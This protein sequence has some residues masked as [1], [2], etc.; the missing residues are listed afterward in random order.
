MQ[1]QA[2]M[3]VNYTQV[4]RDKEIT[5]EIHR[6]IWRA[7]W[8]D[9]FG[10]IT[11]I[12]SR[13]IAFSS[14]HVLIPLVTALAIQTVIEE[15]LTALNRYLWL[16]MLFSA[17]Y[18]V[19][20]TIGQYMISRSAV[21]ALI[22]IQQ[23]V[24]SNFITKD[25]EFFNNNYIGA[26]GAQAIRLR[27]ASS[28]YG[29]ITIYLIPRHL[30]IIIASIVVIG[31]QSL[32]LAL[33]TLVSMII[34]LAFTML[35]SSWRLKFRRLVS[36]AGSVV[37]GQIGDVLT[38]AEAVKS[39]AAEGYEERRLKKPLEKW[40]KAQHK[41]WIAA[42]P[43][44]NGRLLLASIT[45]AVLL[46]A[47]AR[48]Y[49][50]GELSISIVLL[51]QLY[52]IKLVAATMD[53]A[54]TLKR[55]EE[56]MGAAYEPV[57]T[58][59]L[60]PTVNNPQKP[61]KIK[62]SGRYQLN[63]KCVTYHY[64]EAATTEN[65][66]SNLSLTVKK[67]QKI[68]LVGYSGS[69]KTTLTKLILRY[70]D[71]TEGMISLAGQDIRTVKQEDLR[72]L[73]AYVPQEPILFHRSISENIAYG[74]PSADKKSLHKAAK[75]AYVDEFVSKLPLGYETYVGERGVK[76]SGGQRQR[77]AI[78]RALLKD[79]PILILDEATSSLDSKSEK[80]IQEALWKLMKN[81]TAIVIAHRLST[82]QRMDKIVVMDKGRI[83][84]TGTHEEL[85][86]I[87]GIYADLWTHQSGGYLGSASNSW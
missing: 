75:Q 85:K 27:D 72:K 18:A 64:R 54:D 12:I 20:Y 46:F 63:I 58:M 44:D 3:A 67:G 82:V 55:Y 49:V 74:S 15:D 14:Y 22:Y 60:K 65:A 39:F 1:N 38:H 83:V 5:R 61:S 34:V 10:L 36:H 80:L 78:A 84:Q 7:H 23:T 59:M 32:L 24:F 9:K 8:L 62:L 6:L 68:G 29:E 43:S 16:L 21:K 52:V 79:A 48:L 26:L 25:H 87:T 2:V 86:N 37:S 33:I 66:I 53:I 11:G 57:K 70:M 51:I 13:I 69:G 73:I 47:S 71:V 45:T 50:A 56:V 35:S 28:S 17:I 81:R 40:G 42:V 4:K 77:V 31:T 76:L 30:T 41:S 19:F